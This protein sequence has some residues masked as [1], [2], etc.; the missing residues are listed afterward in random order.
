[1][2]L[3]MYRSRTSAVWADALFASTLQ[4]SDGPR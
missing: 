3:L 4:R 2:Q 1:M